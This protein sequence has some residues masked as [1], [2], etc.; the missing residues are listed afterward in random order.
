M[1]GTVERQT[2]SAVV[3]HHLRDAGKHAAA[4]VQGVAVFFGLGDNDMHA[5][6][7]RP[8]NCVTH[9]TQYKAHIF[10]IWLLQLCLFI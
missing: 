3:V 10:N 2:L 6:L 9:G 8:G 1:L 4:L 5:A 7:A